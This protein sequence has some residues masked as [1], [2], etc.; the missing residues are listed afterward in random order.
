MEFRIAICFVEVTS[1]GIY[2]ACSDVSGPDSLR[3]SFTA[4]ATG[5]GGNFFG[6]KLTIL[7]ATQSDVCQVLYNC[8]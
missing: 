7:V 3:P 8:N 5:G 4:A 2:P 1:R 6:E